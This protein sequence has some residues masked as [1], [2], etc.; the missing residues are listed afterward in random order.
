VIKSKSLKATP[1][2][3]FQCYFICFWSI[4]VPDESCLQLRKCVFMANRSVRDFLG[5]FVDTIL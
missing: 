1:L 5:D 2:D 3:H 4:V